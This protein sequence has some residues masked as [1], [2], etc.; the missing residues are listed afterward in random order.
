MTP[1]FED[2]ADLIK[3]LREAERL[4]RKLA[5][6][7]GNETFRYIAEVVGAQMAIALVSTLPLDW[8]VRTC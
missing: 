2:Y 1:Q 3:H 4:S 5:E 7:S 6:D 8:R